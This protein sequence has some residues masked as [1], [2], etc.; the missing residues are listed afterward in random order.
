MKVDLWVVVVYED[1]IHP[2]DQNDEYSWPTTG[3]RPSEAKPVG[4]WEPMAA[5][6][7]NITWRRPYQRRLSDLEILGKVAEP[8]IEED[9][10]SLIAACNKLLRNLV[11]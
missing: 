10:H 9:V 6:D 5:S 8:T 7:G 3:L 1:G 2:N 11:E 4:P